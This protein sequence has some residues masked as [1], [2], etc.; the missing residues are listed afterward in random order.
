[1]KYV[2]GASI[3]LSTL[4]IGLA[5][6]GDNYTQYGEAE[7]WVNGYVYQ[8]GECQSPHESIY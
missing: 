5:L 6:A 2:I 1:M 8:N 3:L 4:L 7:C